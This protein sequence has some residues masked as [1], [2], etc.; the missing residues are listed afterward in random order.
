MLPVNACYQ[1]VAM[2]SLEDGIYFSKVNWFLFLQKFHQNI[3]P[4]HELDKMGH[5]EQ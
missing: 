4:W 1:P 5:Q 3:W 2:A